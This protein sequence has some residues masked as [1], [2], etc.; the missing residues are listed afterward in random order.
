MGFQKFAKHTLFGLKDFGHPRGF[1]KAIPK[2]TLKIY[3]KSFG[4]KLFSL[5]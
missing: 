2:R 1:G 5:K 4:L 3:P